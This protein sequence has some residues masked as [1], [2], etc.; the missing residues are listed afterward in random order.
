MHINS[1]IFYRITNVALGKSLSLGVA[2]TDGGTPS[3]LVDITPS[4]LFSGQ[5]WQFLN[6]SQPGKGTYYLSSS[7][8]GPQKKLDVSM[9]DEAVYI[10]YLKNFT[11][12][13]DQTWVVTAH[14][15][16]STGINGTKY[17]LAPH[18]LGGSK[19]LSVKNDTKQPFLDDVGRDNITALLT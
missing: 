13:H 18:F 9:S 5:V 8:L 11:T 6:P 15:E 7:F 17:S 12:E 10:P 14:N 3:G 1:N 2:N 19:A 16:N 4:G